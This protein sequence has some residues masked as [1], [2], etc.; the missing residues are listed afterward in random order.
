[1]PLEV[2]WYFVQHYA[3]LAVPFYLMSL[4]G[5]Y[6]V[7]ALSDVTWPAYATASTMLYHL[8]PMQAIAHVI[9]IIIVILFVHIIILKCL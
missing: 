4:G 1:M 3:I 8:I 2:E 5:A 9:H 6:K 7:E